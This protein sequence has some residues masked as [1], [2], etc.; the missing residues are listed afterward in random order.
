MG[1]DDTVGESVEDGGRIQ[2]GQ[3]GKSQQEPV[4]PNRI[5]NNQYIYVGVKEGRL[6]HAGAVSEYK[7]VCK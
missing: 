2:D 3:Q 5:T 4:A 6:F 7:S 1:R